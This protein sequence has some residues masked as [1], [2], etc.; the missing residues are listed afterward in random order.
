MAFEILISESYVNRLQK[1]IKVNK[2]FNTPDQDQLYSDA[3]IDR[4]PRSVLLQ[5]EKTMKREATKDSI[6]VH[7][8]SKFF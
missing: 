5:R 6:H 1:P 2:S 8:S 7:V 4:I 3:W